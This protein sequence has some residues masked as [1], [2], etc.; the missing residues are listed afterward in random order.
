MLQ[1]NHKLEYWWWVDNL[2]TW[3]TS[4]ICLMLLFFDVS[5]FMSC[6]VYWS[7][8]HLN[9]ITGSGVMTIFVYK[10]LTKNQENV[11]THSEFC[12]ISGELRKRTIPNLVEMCLMKSYL[13]LQNARFIAFTASELLR[14]NQWTIRD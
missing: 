3:R 10:R 4:Q 2:L 14:E 6:Y 13:L 8:F 1:I 5:L 12:P 7:K 9:I 11:N